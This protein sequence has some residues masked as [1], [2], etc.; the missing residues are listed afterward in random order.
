VP[1]GRCRVGWRRAVE[2]WGATDEE[3]AD[4]WPCDDI[5]LAADL[6]LWR[7]VEV[8]APPAVLFRWLCQ[9][10]VAPYSYDWLDN[11]GRRSPRTLTPGL[12]QLE[13]GQ[14]FMT[15]FRL[16]SFAADDHVTLTSHTA[17]FGDIAVTYRARARPGAGSRLAVKIRVQAPRGPHGWLCRTVLP[18]GDL[19]MMRRQLLH[20][21][22][23]A[24]ASAVPVPA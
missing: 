21:A 12:D 7:A 8:A 22:E 11:R 5:P 9:L 17:A 14:R 10:R 23:L 1:Y 2:R 6:V 24:A 3:V 20:L 19:V 13:I 4:R 16:A 18:A 15:I